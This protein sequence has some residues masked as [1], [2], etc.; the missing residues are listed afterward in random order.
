MPRATKNAAT[1]AITAASAKK[2]PVSRKTTAKKTPAPKVTKPK[3][4]RSF[5]VYFKGVDIKTH[6]TGYQP[7]QAARKAI[8]PI[9]RHM[10]VGAGITDKK[11]QK[12]NTQFLNKEFIF[13][14]VEN[15]KV[16]EDENP[17]PRHYYR[18]IR[19]SVNPDINFYLTKI[20]PTDPEKKRKITIDEKDYNGQITKDAKGNVIEVR[21]PHKFK[22]YE[23]TVVKGPDGKDITQRKVIREDIK[24]IPYKHT[25]DV[26]KLTVEY[27][28][29]HKANFAL[30][31]D[32]EAE[33]LKYI[34]K[35]KKIRT[36][37]AEVPPT[38]VEAASTE[39]KKRTGRRKKTEI[40]A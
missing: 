30:T 11:A 28:N 40:V 36:P 4:K 33:L 7:K 29:E 10:L 13:Y 31:A 1:T 12:E 18:G 16:A 9:I 25:N 17:P 34:D 27:Y 32:E 24:Y 19:K 14:I 38:P 35:P 26:S 21:I 39:T 37:K 20:D 15:K 3:M 23:D 8:T 6:P 5:S 22:I 2:T